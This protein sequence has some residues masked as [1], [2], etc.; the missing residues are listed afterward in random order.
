[1]RAI[2][3]NQNLKPKQESQWTNATVRANNLGMMPTQGISLKIKI[4]GIFL[5][6]GDQR[7]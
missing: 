1:M 3:D 4:M 2:E 7:V 5:K 6:M